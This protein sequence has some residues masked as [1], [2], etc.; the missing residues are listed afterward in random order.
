MVSVDCSIVHVIVVLIV[1]HVHRK[2]FCA[3]PAAPLA[4]SC[5]TCY[6][7]QSVL[8]WTRDGARSHV[9]LLQWF[10]SVCMY[11]VLPRMTVCC[12]VPSEQLRLEVYAGART[13]SVYPI[14][15][16]FCTTMHRFPSHLLRL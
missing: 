1:M 4:L 9:R 11:G 14:R 12:R 5:F 7:A 15:S 6:A 8:V 13:M 10:G 2:K 3:R 16:L